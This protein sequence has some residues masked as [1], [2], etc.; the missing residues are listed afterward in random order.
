MILKCKGCRIN[1]GDEIRGRR[2]FLLSQWQRLTAERSFVASGRRGAQNLGGW[3]SDCVTLR[4]Y[5]NVLTSRDLVS[6]LSP[7]SFFRDAR[8]KLILIAIRHCLFERTK[9]S[10]G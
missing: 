5:K 7:A 3:G 1:E 6:G 10:A 2:A 4:A 9:E 8:G